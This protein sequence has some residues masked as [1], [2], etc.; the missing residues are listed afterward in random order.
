MEKLSQRN[1]LIFPYEIAVVANGAE[2][3]V[4]MFVC[5][6]ASIIRCFVLFTNVG[7][8][9]DIVITIEADCSSV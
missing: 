5:H 2:I 9:L 1:I 8:L 3:V 7:P 4:V 6:L